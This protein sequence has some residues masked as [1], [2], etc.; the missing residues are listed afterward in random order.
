MP[1]HPL[2]L[3]TLPSTRR[4]RWNPSNTAPT[5]TPGAAVNASDPAS[6]IDPTGTPSEC[7]G[8]WSGNQW[9]GDEIECHM[10]SEDWQLK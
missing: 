1:P 4:R 10:C 8:F 3:A 5:T 7:T 9:S 2:P 6:W